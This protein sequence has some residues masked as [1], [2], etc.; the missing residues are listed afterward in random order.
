[1]PDSDFL[2]LPVHWL[3]DH[4]VLVLTAAALLLAGWFLARLAARGILRLFSRAN[5]VDQNYGPLLSQV[6]R[7][8]IMGF[9]IIAALNLLGVAST[10]ILAVLG[11]AGLAIALALQGTLSNIAAGLMLL[12]LRPIA[13]GEFIQGDGVAGV[14]VEIGLFGTR[15]RS[16]SG[17][18]IFTPNQKLWASAIT[19]HSREPR[20]RVDVNVSVPDSIDI[21]NSRKILL[22][23][24]TSDERVE[25]NPPPS[26]H[27]DSF[28]GSAV[29][30][31]LRAWVKTPQYLAVLF[32]LTEQAKLALNREL[33]GSKEEK[34]LINVA[35]NPNEANP[36]TRTGI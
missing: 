6:V 4:A 8:G 17:L 22:R 13:I 25:V 24:A 19:N 3:A 10:T 14:V 34:A 27:V 29:N 1:M 31:Q 23:I 36:E 35:P 33:D 16:S 32:D 11:A 9:A 21:A 18:Y 30:M 28:T 20:R 15:L 26:V 12:W 2:Y 7:Y 5:G